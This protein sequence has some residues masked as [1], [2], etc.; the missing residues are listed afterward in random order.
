MSE[1]FDYSEIPVGPVPWTCELGCY[2]RP[3]LRITH[4]GL[5]LCNCPLEIIN[6][7]MFDLV[8][9]RQT[10]MEQR[11][12]TVVWRLVLPPAGFSPPKDGLATHSPTAR[13]S[14]W[15]YTQPITRWGKG[16]PHSAVNLCP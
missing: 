14:S 9:W 8:I 16:G 6:N 11:D 7:F 2:M 12:V 15:P 13:H 1:K 3:L 5:M 10:L 4:I